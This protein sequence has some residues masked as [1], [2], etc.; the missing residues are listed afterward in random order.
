MRDCTNQVK[1]IVAQCDPT[2]VSYVVN[3]WDAAAANSKIESIRRKA[4]EDK[5]IAKHTGLLKP[6]DWVLRKIAEFSVKHGYQ[7]LSAWI[8]SLR[9]NTERRNLVES[10][11]GVMEQ[12][13]KAR[14]QGP[15]AGG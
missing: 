3:D 12:E 2:D 4:A 15:A 7:R 13:A 10:A 1:A 6:L 8:G 5:D 11:V 9:P 14:T